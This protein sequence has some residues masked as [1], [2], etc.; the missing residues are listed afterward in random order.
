MKSISFFIEKLLNHEHLDINEAAFL[1]KNAAL[2]DLM[3]AA[4]KFRKSI[5]PNNIVTW[6]I[7]RNV[8][9]TNACISQCKF[10][11]FC[12]KPN[13]DDVFITSIDQYREKIRELTKLGGCQLLLQG[14]LHPLLD[15]NYYENLF[16]QLKSEFPQLKLHALGPP[17]IVY[18]A[19][20][21]NLSIEDT[22]SRLVSAGLDSL[23]GA[24][25]EILVDRVRS[26]VSPAKATASQWL[27][28]MKIAHEMGLI[29]SATMMYG[30]LETIEERIQH[31]FS[32]RDLQQNVTN[33]N[34]GFLAFI[35]WPFMRDHTRL[36]HMDY[37]LPTY[38]ASEYLRLIAFSRLVLY[39]VPN[40]Q[41]SWLTIG[42]E[43]AKIALTAG[44]NDLGSIMIEENVVSSTGVSITMTKEQMVQTIQEAGYIPKI[45][46]QAYQI[47]KN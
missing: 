25:A 29:T 35:P 1:Y 42:K 24:G 6:I 31:L 33:G 20:I 18:I 26:I 15:I 8:N 46:N 47:V 19:K 28:V 11:S 7:D 37:N 43:V 44:A 4:N 10:C 23:P 16:I 39:N 30:H 40:I 38:S 5:H 13:A 45:R 34:P 21:S 3:C 17:E 27:S 22:L 36:N 32:I 2:A 14:G 12:T 9:I 41:A